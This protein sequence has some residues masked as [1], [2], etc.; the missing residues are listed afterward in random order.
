MSSA[1]TAEPYLYFAA[2]PRHILCAAAIA[3]Q[4]GEGDH[5]L[6]VLDRLSTTDRSAY[7]AVLAEWQATPFSRVVWLPSDVGTASSWA[8][9]AL[10]RPR[11]LWQQL[12][13]R[14]TIRR[15][16]AAA[17]PARLHVALDT[18]FE[19]QCALHHAR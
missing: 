10:R 19:M 17:P 8:D 2:R 1:T 7:A 9:R 4:H 6:F 15:E 16:L 12:C 18:R 3:L 11:V 13:N 5:R 14:A